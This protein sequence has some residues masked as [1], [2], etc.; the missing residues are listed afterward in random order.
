MSRW[1]PI[2]RSIP[3]LLAAA[4]LG[5]MSC[6]QAAPGEVMLL[7]S[8]DLAV[9]TD[10]DTLHVT[11]TRAGDSKAYFDESYDLGA[12][13]SSGPR[14]KQ[15]PGTFALVSSDETGGPVHVHLELLQGKDGPIQVQRDAEVQIPTEGVKQLPMLL[16]FLCLDATLPEACAAGT[17]CQAGTCVDDKSTGLTDYVTPP[18]SACFNLANCFGAINGGN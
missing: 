10:V 9:P 3:P 4:S 7:V 11:V 8:T 18:S 2:R 1:A 6:G 16:D 15:L 5:S 13:P 12:D 14:A 17:T